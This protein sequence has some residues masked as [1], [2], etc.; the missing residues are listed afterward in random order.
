MFGHFMEI[1]LKYTNKI[2]VWTFSEKISVKIY[3][4][5]YC[6]C[7]DLSRKFPEIYKFR[8]IGGVSRKVP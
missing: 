6:I 2:I 3:T 4:Y 8:K 7:M 1:S 5:S